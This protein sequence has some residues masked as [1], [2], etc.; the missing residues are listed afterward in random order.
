MFTLWI[1]Y[2][3]NGTYSLADGH[4]FFRHGLGVGHVVLHDGLEE[5]IF[6]FS[7]KRGLR[8]QTNT[9]SLW[10]LLLL[11]CEDTGVIRAACEGATGVCDL[12]GLYSSWSHAVHGAIGVVGHFD[13]TN[14]VK[15]ISSCRFYMCS[16]MCDY[17]MY[18][19]VKQ[20]CSPKSCCNSYLWESFCVWFIFCHKKKKSF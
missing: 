11:L 18:S 9:V 10:G 15:T 17:N 2:S 12:T 13:D 8:R 4:S 6:I 3:T 7:I 1:Q 14:K 19:V 16:S 20:S 5:L